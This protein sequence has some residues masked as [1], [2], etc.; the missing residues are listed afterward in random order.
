MD[1]DKQNRPRRKSE[2]SSLVWLGY[3]FN[4]FSS[5]RLPVQILYMNTS[6]LRSTL[7][8]KGKYSYEAIQF[9]LQGAP[10]LALR[11]LMA[12]P[13][14]ATA[15]PA[16]PHAAL[17]VLTLAGRTDE[18]A[19]KWP[20]ELSCTSVDQEVKSELSLRF[21]TIHIWSINSETWLWK[22]MEVLYL[23][24]VILLKLIC[25][26]DK[27]V[28]VFES[29]SIVPMHCSH[30]MDKYAMLLNKIAFDS[31]KNAHTIVVPTESWQCCT[32]EY[33]ITSNLT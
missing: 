2:R 25:T 16:T 21:N 8:I 5:T 10:A 7:T 15:V 20:T 29:W 22:C 19:R 27:Y 24:I 32:L 14:A 31:E 23:S 28:Q 1:V 3:Q 11:L 30:R 12:N 6:I 4:I 18:E 33:K 9:T 17:E 26:H 13:T